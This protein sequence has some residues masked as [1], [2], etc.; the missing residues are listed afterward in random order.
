MQFLYWPEEGQTY[1][2]LRMATDDGLPYALHELRH[3]FILDYISLQ[4]QPDSPDYH[5]VTKRVYK[6]ISER[7]VY[8][9][10][11]SSR[12]Y[13]GMIFYYVWNRMTDGIFEFFIQNGQIGDA[14]DLV[15]LVPIVHSVK[16]N[17]DSS[18]EVLIR[19]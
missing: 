17:M 2:T 10:L 4:C 13:G 9:L 14:A 7:G 16:Y 1:E 19:E 8:N 6:D 11:K 12:H 5:R 15:R 3:E 18:D